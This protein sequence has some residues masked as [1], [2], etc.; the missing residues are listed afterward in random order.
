MISIIDYG[1]GN[2]GSIVNMFKK[3]G[4][5]SQIIHRPEEL[6]QATK[7]ILPGVGAFDTGIKHLQDHGW[8]APL[9]KKVMVERIPIMGICLGMQL[10]TKGSEEGKFDGLG[11]I[12]A[13]TRKFQPASAEVKIP[14]M[15]WSKADIVK[16]SKLL[17]QKNNSERRFYFVHSYFV[18]VNNAEDELLRCNYGNNFTAGFERNNIIGVQFHPE[19]SHKF[20]MELFGN[21]ANN[22]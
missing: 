2:L 3:I 8:L 16:E 17:I 11:W 10:M 1:L 7:L 14:H 6:D 13:Y 12:D 22:Y 20:G 9:E 15:G 19:K 21:F 18:S 4:Y 5:Q